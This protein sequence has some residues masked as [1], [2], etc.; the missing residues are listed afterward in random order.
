MEGAKAA[1]RNVCTQVGSRFL[2]MTEQ[3]EFDVYVE[4]AANYRAAC[5]RLGEAAGRPEVQAY[6]K[7]VDPQFL[8]A[9]QFILP[10]LLKAPL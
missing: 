2:E 7:S 3:Q 5:D 4:Y 9:T 1:Q 8:T 6:L 10:E